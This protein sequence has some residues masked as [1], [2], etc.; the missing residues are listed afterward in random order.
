[1]RVIAG[2]TGI[3]RFAPDNC[4]ISPEDF[5]RESKRLIKQYHRQGR[6]LYAIAPRLRSV[7]PTK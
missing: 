5:Y 3:D 1:M 7:A 4:K 6:N 2:L